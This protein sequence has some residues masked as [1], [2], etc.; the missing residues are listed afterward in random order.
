VQFQK[1]INSDLS[2]EGKAIASL[3]MNTT[4]INIDPKDQANVQESINNLTNFTL[5]KLAE[6][7]NIIAGHMIVEGDSKSI[8]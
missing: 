7:K 1:A 2:S 4:R 8:Y 3:M 6:R 5:P